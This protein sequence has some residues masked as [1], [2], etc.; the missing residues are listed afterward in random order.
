MLRTLPGVR[1]KKEKQHA[2]D[3]ERPEEETNEHDDNRQAS[4]GFYTVQ[5]P[6]EEVARIESCSVGDKAM[7]LLERPQGSPGAQEERIRQRAEACA[8]VKY[9]GQYVFYETS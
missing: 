8:R 4:K 6:Q 7:R 5:L 3:E 2:E 9:Q 1:L